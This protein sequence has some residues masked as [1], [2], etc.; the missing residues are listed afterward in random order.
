MHLRERSPASAPQDDEL[1]QVASSESTLMQLQIYCQPAKTAPSPPPEPRLCDTQ[2]NVPVSTLPPQCGP[3]GRSNRRPLH[4]G[5]AE[6]PLASMV[7]LRIMSR[8]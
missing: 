1:P 3:Q 5:T 8:R 6:N 4:T 2:G 7:T